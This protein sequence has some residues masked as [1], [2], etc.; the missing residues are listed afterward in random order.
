M[1]E[2]NSFWDVPGVSDVPDVPGIPSVSFRLL[3]SAAK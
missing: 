3:D 1:N 2:N